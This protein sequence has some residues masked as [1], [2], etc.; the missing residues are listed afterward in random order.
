[1]T[2]IS[3]KSAYPIKAPI[4]DDYI[5]GTNSEDNKGTVNFSFLDV[6]NLI[7][8][9]N[10]VNGLQFTFS[11][12]SDEELDYYSPGLMFTED[13][14]VDS[15][16]FTKLYVNKETLQLFD[17]T[18]LFSLLNTLEHVVLKIE[19]P[20]D[21]NF[22]LNL[23]ITGI[24]DQDGYFIF[25]VEP[26]EDFVLGDLTNETTYSF[27]FDIKAN[28]SEI[29]DRLELLG[30][31]PKIQFIANGVDNTFDLTTTAKVK[32]VFWN[33]ALLDD[34]DWSQTLNILTI[35]TFTPNSGEIIKP[36]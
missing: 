18:P 32:A 3:N 14:E 30:N 28:P 1:M 35:V 25:D 7:N 10:G 33:G 22:A 9:I 6:A 11:D 15:K 19:N 12:G 5:V 21:V 29:D 36:I 8:R 13:N 31:F 16:V 17:M 34:A 2:K 24:S 4:M 23:K 20:S 26:Y 27:Y